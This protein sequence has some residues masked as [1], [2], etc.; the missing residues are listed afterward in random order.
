MKKF[1]IGSHVIGDKKNCMIVAE[2][3]PNHNGNFKNAL[4]LINLA[5]KSGCDAVK[6]Q[7][8]LADYEL[9]DKKSRSYYF[10]KPR[11]EFIKKVQ[12]FSEKQHKKLREYCRKK[13]LIY[14]CS[15]FSEK[16]LELLLKIKPDAI[17]VPSGELNNL[18]LLEKLTKIKEPVIISSGMSELDEI[19]K[20]LSLFRNKYKKILLHC[21][22]EYPTKVEDINLKFINEIEKEL[23]IYSGLSDHSRN[24][25]VLG[26][27]VALGARMIEVHFTKNTNLKGPDHKVSLMPKEMI[28]LVNKKNIILKA[29]GQNNKTLGK[30]VKKMR[31]TFTN[32]IYSKMNLKKGQIITKKNIF[33]MK[34]GNGLS[35]FDYQKIL[36]RRLNKNIKK[37]N[38]ILL[39]DV[40]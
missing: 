21:T 14:I 8:R 31:N 30:H 33:F 32:S 38:L 23:K 29:L 1:N 39:R 10:N 34:P 20:V 5:K 4:N 18:W 26:S 27:A 37:N 36:N 25:D 40:K 12:E 16:S 3:G 7:Y 2:I 9:V 6:F 17:K 35:P 15:V 19:Q 13:K 24:L 28:E 11:Y 22:S